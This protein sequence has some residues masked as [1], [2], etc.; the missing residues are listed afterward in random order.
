MIEEPTIKPRVLQ[1]RDKPQNQGLGSIQNHYSLHPAKHDMPRNIKLSYSALA[2]GVEDV[3]VSSLRS[4][5]DEMD[6]ELRIVSG[7]DFLAKF[8]VN[9]RG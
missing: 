9:L 5:S 3:F 4:S 6:T 8:A 7:G 2:N 1:L